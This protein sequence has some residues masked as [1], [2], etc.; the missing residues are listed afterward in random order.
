[1]LL[2]K[3][4]R[5]FDA[6]REYLKHPLIKTDTITI[7]YPG[8]GERIEHVMEFVSI[9]CD[10]YQKLIVYLIDPYLNV[11][12]LKSKAKQYPDVEFQVFKEPF[13]PDHIPQ[14]LTIYLERAFEL[15]RDQD[16]INRVVKNLAKNGLLI[17]DAQIRHKQL[18]SLKLP[19]KTKEIGFYPFFDIHRKL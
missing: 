15:F 9:L 7:L 4:K 14:N 6:L 3:E 1:M 16:I 10:T 18:Q 11:E 12:V 17:S 5:G 13:T 8:S 19:S 2:P